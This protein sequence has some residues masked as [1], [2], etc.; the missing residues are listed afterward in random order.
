MEQLPELKLAELESLKHTPE[1]LV[2]RWDTH[3][4]EGTGLHKGR[5]LFSGQHKRTGF[6]HQV[7]CTLS[8]KLLA[9]TDPVP[10]ARHD[11]YAFR[12]HQ[13]ERFL[14]ESALADKGYIGLGC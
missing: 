8:G 2:A 11:V 4:G 14:D 10:G 5:T 13:L 12:F 1:S 7:I 3:S 9:I 6:T